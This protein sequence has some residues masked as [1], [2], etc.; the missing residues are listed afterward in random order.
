LTAGA[1]NP[2]QHLKI[3]ENGR[4]ISGIEEKPAA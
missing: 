2:Q 4:E 1:I 3:G